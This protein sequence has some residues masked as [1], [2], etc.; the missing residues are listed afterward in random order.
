V[1]V[2]VCLCVR[3]CGRQVAMQAITEE[4]RLQ[5]HKQFAAI[6]VDASGA[7]DFAEISVG[8]ERGKAEE[9]R[10]EREGERRRERERE[11]ERE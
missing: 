3:V 7:L 9:G 5:I 1:F 8:G 2:S 10:G 4:E 6:D 11:R